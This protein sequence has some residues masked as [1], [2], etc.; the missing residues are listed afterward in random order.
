M[1]SG[2]GRYR[3]NM[4]SG[5]LRSGGLCFEP[6]LMCPIEGMGDL[7]VGHSRGPPLPR[8]FSNRAVPGVWLNG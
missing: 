3:G 1:V 2:C 6:R 7:V 5:R 8:R 4:E